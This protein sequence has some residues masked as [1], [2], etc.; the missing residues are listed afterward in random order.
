MTGEVVTARGLYRTFEAELAPVRA[1]RGADLDVSAGEFVAIMGP[2]G[3]GKSTLL[4][5]VAGLDRADEGEIVGRGGE[6]RRPRRQPARHAPARARR[7]RLPVLQPARDD[8]RARER[9]HA[10]AD[11]GNE[12]PAGRGPGPRP[13]RPARHRRQGRP[14]AR[15]AVGWSAPAP[16]DRAR[17]R[18]RT[19]AAPGRRADRR[20]RLR[21]WPRDPRAVPTPARTGSD[22]PPRDPRPSGR[23]RRAADRAH[24][25][26]SRRRRRRMSTRPLPPR[27]RSRETQRW[28][29][30]GSGSVP[31][32]DADGCR[33]SSSASSPAWSSGSRPPR[34]AAPP[35]SNPP[36]C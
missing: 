24:A 9:P 12:A 26:R 4:N 34:V 15:G 20:A 28:L 2:S 29:P 36:P 17:P 23:R 22:D 10:R 30:S 13:A 6:P 14:G 21:G 35:G 32:S 25:R 27:P 11:R 18:E 33:G 19:D 31:T 1:L 3:C 7:H 16:R 5:L 8:D